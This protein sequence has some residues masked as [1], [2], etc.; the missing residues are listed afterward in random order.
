MFLK[1]ILRTIFKNIVNQL[2]ISLFLSS[3]L[4]WNLNIVIAILIPHKNLK[5]VINRR[6][7]EFAILVSNSNFQ[8]HHKC[9]VKT[10]QNYSN[11]IVHSMQFCSQPLNMHSIETT[12]QHPSG[13]IWISTNNWITASNYSLLINSSTNIE[14]SLLGKIPFGEFYWNVGIKNHIT[15][16]NPK[17]MAKNKLLHLHKQWVRNLDKK[18]LITNNCRTNA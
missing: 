13:S 6:W 11:F 9:W 1:I 8:G 15:Q 7:N 3:F 4:V 16:Q 17:Y 10:A 2:Q 5:I 14:T 18:G 12:I